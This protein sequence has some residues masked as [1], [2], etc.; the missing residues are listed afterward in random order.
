MKKAIL[1][2]HGMGKNTASANGKPGSFGKEFID[3]TNKALRR[4][5]KHANDSIETYCDIH[6][7]NY[8]EW[9]DKMRTIMADNARSMS[10]RLNAIGMFP[11]AGSAAGLVAQLT[12]FEAKFK[13]DQFFYTHWLDVLFYGTML[14]AKVRVDA[15]A[16]IN[17]LVEQYGGSNVHIIAHSL[18]T[19]L[20]HDTLHLLYRA[21]HDPNDQIPDLDVT[22]HKLGSIW[23]FANVSRLV[24]S[25]TRLSD[26]LGS[27]VRPG[28]G[29]CTFKFTNTRH[30]LDPFTWPA[31]FNPP[32]D[33]SWVPNATYATDYRP[34]VIDLI[35][36]ANTHSFTQ[37]LSDPK[38]V[39]RLLPFF[40]ESK[41]QGTIPEFNQYVADYSAQSIQGAFTALQDSLKDALKESDQV[42]GWMDFFNQAKA[43]YEAVKHI[44]DNF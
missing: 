4:F 9:F 7:F 33:G 10:D 37:Y 12:A 1:L 29:G 2:V 39:E 27:L 25:I 31:R 35:L 23:M 32:N 3:A 5:S 43:F 22:T 18:G 41:F 28:V 15:A 13:N 36:D 16:K 40:L 11:G 14:G 19:A 8:N 42:T 21:E 24:N 6:E 34:I 44:K 26:P 38:V 20:T 30:V 17:A